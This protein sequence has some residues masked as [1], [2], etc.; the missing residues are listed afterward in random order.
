MYCHGIRKIITNLNQTPGHSFNLKSPKYEARE[1][2]TQNTTGHK[3]R[4]CKF[5]SMTKTY[6]SLTEQYRRAKYLGQLSNYSEYI[7][8]CN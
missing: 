8:D 1:L 5:E 4:H 6:R 3:E 7:K 2:T